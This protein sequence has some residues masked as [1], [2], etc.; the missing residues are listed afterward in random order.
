MRVLDLAALR[1]LVTIAERGGVT[2]AANVLNL[3]QSAVSMQMKR[4]EEALDV[5]L[6]QRQ[7]RTV[8]LTSE[9][10]QLVGYARR[11]LDLNDEAVTRL[12]AQEFEGTLRLGVPHDIVYPHIPEILQRLATEFPRVKV[13]LSSSF[14]HKLKS[15][16][17]QGEVDV[18]LTTEQYVPEGAEA[19]AT[20][21]MVWIGREGG[22]VWRQRPLR[23]AFEHGCI[24]RTPVQEA[25]EEAGIPWELAVE[26][27]H[28]RTVEASI[29]ADL[30]IH[31]QLR[32]SYPLGCAEVPE[33]AGLP[34]LPSSH[35]NLYCSAPRPSKALERMI[36]LL[37]QSYRS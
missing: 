4:L 2:R 21:P 20:L 19:L 23:L 3:T 24:F 34:E 31:V 16:L 8:S 33:A 11:M 28:S 10:E 30:A 14:T 12:T 29:A 26:S 22:Q 9:G 37:R 32:G 18:I 7:A 5:Q 27:D 15:E 36:E 25:L 35:I 13:L 1:S 6:L 17:Q